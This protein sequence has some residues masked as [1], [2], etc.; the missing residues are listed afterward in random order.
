VGVAGLLFSTMSACAA[1]PGLPAAPAFSVK[2]CVTDAQPCSSAQWAK[3]HPAPAKDVT[4]TEKPAPSDADKQL[5]A[6]YAKGFKEGYTD[7]VHAQI[8]ANER[9]KSHQQ[10]AKTQAAP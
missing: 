2:A 1:A 4:A 7:A 9:R 5:T 8:S 3:D 6:Q 10:P